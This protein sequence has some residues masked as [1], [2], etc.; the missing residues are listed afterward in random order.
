VDWLKRRK[1]ERLPPEA[2][3]E[4][5][6]AAVERGGPV[7]V[8]FHHAEMD[9]AELDAAAELLTLLAGHEH[10]RCVRMRIVT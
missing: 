10:A 9:R 4:L 7:G 8:M 6:A 5:A 3:A 1:G 2:I